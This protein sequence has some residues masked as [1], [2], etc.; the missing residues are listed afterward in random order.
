M[1]Q[2][3]GALVAVLLLVALPAVAVDPGRAEGTLTIDNTK[4][5]LNYAYAVGRQKNLLNDRKELT[6][7]ILTDKPLPAD[8]KLTDL[9]DNLP[10]DLNGVILCVDKLGR[11]GHVAVQHPTG[12]YDGGYF[13]G[14]ADYD[15]KPHKGESGTYSGTTSSLRVKTNTMTFSFEATFVASMK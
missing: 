4:I 1:R 5:P 14:I 2:V 10:G 8:A 7:I 13:E 6:R 11:V 3:A 15:F 9:D 12:N